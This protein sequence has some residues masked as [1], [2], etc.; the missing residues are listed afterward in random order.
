MHLHLV[1]LDVQ[2]AR[3]RSG[4]ETRA[5]RTG[6]Y[7][8]APRGEGNGA[9]QRLHRRVGEVGK[10]ELRF[11]LPR[12]GVERRHVGIELARAGATGELA[13]LGQLPLAVDLFHGRRIPLQLQR[14]AALNGR[15]VAIGHHRDALGIAIQR[16]AQHGLHALDGARRAVVHRCEAGAEHR[17]AGDHRRQLPGKPNVD[18]EILAPAALGA[19]V[20]AR[21]GAP[22]DAE[23]LGILQR[24][25]LGHRQSHGGLGQFAV[26]QLAT[27]R[28][29][30]RAG[31]RAQGGDADVPARRRG[32]QQHGP[33]TRA[34]L[35]VLSEAVL[36]RMGAAGEMNAEERVDVGGVVR[37]VPA[38]HQVPIRVQFLSQD[39]RQRGLHALA[40]LQPVD[41]HRDLAVDGD[42]HEGRWLI[43]GLE[44]AG[45]LCRSQVGKGAER[46]AAGTRQ[47]EET[48]ARQRRG[49]ARW[50][51]CQ[52]A[53]QGARQLAVIDVGEHGGSFR[54]ACGLRRQRRRGCERRCRSGRCCR[55]WPRRSRRQSVACREEAT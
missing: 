46:Q 29:Q 3:H 50:P 36:D 37:A 24:D 21:G 6:P 35:A 15:P 18:T 8:R 13:V 12:R 26:T 22:D 44:R 54:R 5:L 10:H 32:A 41:G 45:R 34:E 17:R 28:A 40:E 19:R 48:P 4:V 31:L 1:G 11:Q 38:A 52:Q 20:Q 49:F 53:L 42:L 25:F 39:H 16:H 30:Y 7:L 14:L 9:V 23:V 33:R 47:L 27:A 55:P 51:R 43:R 2:H